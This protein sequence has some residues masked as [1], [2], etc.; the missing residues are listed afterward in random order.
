MT[1][2]ATK[3]KLPTWF[4]IIAGLGLAWNIFGVVQFL[5]TFNGTLE[6]LIR[7]GLT[8]EQAKLYLSLPSWMTAS[9]AIGVFGGVIGSILLLMRKKL[10][11]S[12]F[13]LSLAGYIV[14]Y[15]GDITEGVFKVFGTP[16]AVI[17]TSVVLIAA[18]LLWFSRSFTTSG[19]LN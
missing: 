8:S 6:S 7:N 4:W 16:Q 19:H 11:V 12:V 10:S 17:L 15:I 13:L 18:S 9:F 3:A 2:T 5:S 1:N 14:L